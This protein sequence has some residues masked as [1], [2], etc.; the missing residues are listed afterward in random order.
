MKKVL[1][2][3]YGANR[4]ARM[5]TAITGKPESELVGHPAV[6]EG[7]TLAVQRLDQIPDTISPDAPIRISPQQLL[8]EVWGEDFE[9]YVI[10]ASPNGKVNGTVWELT[11]DERER[12]RDW[13]LLDFGWYHDVEGRVR[14]DDG[15][16]IAVVTEALDDY[17]QIDREVDGMNYE[18]WVIPAQYLE[19]EAVR[20]RGEYDERILKNSEG[21]HFN[22]LNQS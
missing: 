21:E 2:F 14:L 6:L 9:S 10:K 11:E 22:E 3:G 19:R 8:R 16:E 12:V 4:D 1:Y 18:T 17:Q 15:S 5:I 7:Y 13:E 20:T